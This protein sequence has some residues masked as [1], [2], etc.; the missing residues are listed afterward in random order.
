MGPGA[1]LEVLVVNTELGGTW[2][3][4]ILGEPHVLYL[5]LPVGTDETTQSLSRVF[6]PPLSVH[7]NAANSAIDSP[8]RR[9]YIGVYNSLHC[10]LCTLT[11]PL[12]FHG[13]NKLLL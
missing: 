5:Y 10:Y 3:E 11:K 7:K 8:Q 1:G 13:K 4:T 6:G 12:H 2:K 9:V